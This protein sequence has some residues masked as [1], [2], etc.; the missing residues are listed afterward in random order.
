MMGKRKPK[1][2]SMEALRERVA[3]WCRERGGVEID[4]PRF[5]SVMNGVLGGTWKLETKIGPWLVHL[6]ADAT[7]E[8]FFSINTRF[9]DWG[10]G[11]LPGDANQHSGKWNFNGGDIELLFKTFTQCAERFIK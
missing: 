5:N 3:N 11:R 2:V 9:T 6:P 10:E 7:I 4:Q 8:N 1:P